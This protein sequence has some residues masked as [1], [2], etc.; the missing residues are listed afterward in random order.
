MLN[1]LYNQIIYSD[2]TFR[3]K[4]LK[5]LFILTDVWS[6]NSCKIDSPETEMSIFALKLLISTELKNI[7][8]NC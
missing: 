3:E 6:K 1:I 8:I 4:M 2:W 5:F 7:T